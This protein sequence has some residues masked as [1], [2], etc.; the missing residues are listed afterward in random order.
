VQ[1]FDDGLYRERILA[2]QEALEFLQGGDNSPRFP[3]KRRLAD[4]VDSVV[5]VKLEEHEIRPRGVGDE[6]LLAD[7]LHEKS[8][9]ETALGQLSNLHWGR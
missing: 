4:A 8:S 5:G 6:N 1:A 3:F 9:A 2:D 7:D